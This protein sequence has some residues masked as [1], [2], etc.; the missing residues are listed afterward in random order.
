MVKNM[1]EFY[2][3]KY[4]ATLLKTPLG[5]TV[6]VFRNITAAKR[7][8]AREN[9]WEAAQKYADIRIGLYGDEIA[10]YIS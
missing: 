8:N 9:F 5:G 4:G 10:L 2:A 7:L 3:K 6:A 1:V